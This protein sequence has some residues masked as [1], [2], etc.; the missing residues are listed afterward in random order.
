MFNVN[1]IQFGIFLLT[2]FMCQVK[3]DLTRTNIV[4]PFGMARIKVINEFIA[5]SFPLFDMFVFET[6]LI[7]FVSKGFCQRID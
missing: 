5:R 1:K 3:V 6:K 7:A 2:Q 4:W